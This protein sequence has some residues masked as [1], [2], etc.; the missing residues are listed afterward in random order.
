ML[1]RACDRLMELSASFDEQC[2]EFLCQPSNFAR[3]QCRQLIYPSLLLLLL[4]VAAGLSFWPSI[5]LTAGVFPAFVALTWWR[6][7][8]FGNDRNSL[9]LIGLTGIAIDLTLWFYMTRS[10][11]WGLNLLLLIASSALVWLIFHIRALSLPLDGCRDMSLSAATGGDP[12]SAK[13]RHQARSKVC[14]WCGVPRSRFDHHCLFIN[15]CVYDATH[16]AFVLLLLLATAL[17][18]VFVAGTL[19]L[20]ASQA[21]DEIIPASSLEQ[22]YTIQRKFPG[23]FAVDVV[24][25]VFILGVLGV[26]AQQMWGI[27]Y[28]P[29]DHGFECSHDRNRRFLGAVPVAFG[30]RRIRGASV[31][32]TLRCSRVCNAADSRF[33]HCADGT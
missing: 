25:C 4:V 3:M 1:F 26:L 20:C 10:K 24:N 33:N 2:N 16:R 22:L 9:L 14:A 11:H 13:A 12:E 29:R 6:A 32:A 31:C 8:Y 28:A 23:L 5:M 21:Q 27:G 7:V 18:L 19:A 30:M 15:A 17:A